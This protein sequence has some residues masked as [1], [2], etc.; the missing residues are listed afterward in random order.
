MEALFL[1]NRRRIFG[2]GSFLPVQFYHW[3]SGSGLRDYWRWLPLAHSVSRRL[4]LA[5]FPWRLPAL[6]RRY[7]K[8]RRGWDEH[9]YYYWN[10]SWF[11]P[12]TERFFDRRPLP[13]VLL[14]L[15]VADRPVIP[16]APYFLVD[17]PA[18]VGAQVAR[19]GTCRMRRS[20]CWCR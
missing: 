12:H 17:L 1:E 8:M 18:V 5:L 15:A 10:H 13:L 2:V 19:G 20:S 3:W 4:A 6:F 14:N 9:Q 16:V 7:L 11:D